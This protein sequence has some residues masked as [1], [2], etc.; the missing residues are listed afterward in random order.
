[1]NEQ[2]DTGDIILQEETAIFDEETFGELWNRLSKIGSKLLIKT[3]SQIEKG[4]NP[5]IKQGENFSIAPMITKE[6]SKIDWENKT[7]YEIKNLVRALN[8]IMG[9]Y[10]FLNDKKIK[11]WKVDFVKIEEFISKYKEFEQ[12]SYRFRQH[13]RRNYTIY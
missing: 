8:P 1:M 2:M 12:Y 13:R 11:F 7:A 5:R 3:I 6:M 4:I 10:T 9:T